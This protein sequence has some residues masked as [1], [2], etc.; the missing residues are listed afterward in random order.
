MKEVAALSVQK[1]ELETIRIEMLPP[2][3]IVSPESGKSVE[4]EGW[5]NKHSPSDDRFYVSYRQTGDI[6]CRSSNLV[7]R[8]P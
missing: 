8:G 6:K 4:T 2:S 7:I 3:P 5:S 1:S